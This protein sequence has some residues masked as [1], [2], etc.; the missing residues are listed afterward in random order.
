MENKINTSKT[1]ARRYPEMYEKIV[2]FA[3]ALVVVVLLI[4]V[5]ITFGVALGVF[6]RPV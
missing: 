2:P 6:A 1:P 4:L 3:I 5:V